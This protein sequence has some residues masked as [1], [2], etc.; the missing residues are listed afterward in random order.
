MRTLIRISAL[1]LLGVAVVSTSGCIPMP[2]RTGPTEV[3]VRTVKLGIMADK[4]VEDRAY[5]TR[6]N[7]LVHSV[8]YGLAH[9]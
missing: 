3:G 1:A 7:A 5:E 2:Y 6:H 4:G 9:L 8:L